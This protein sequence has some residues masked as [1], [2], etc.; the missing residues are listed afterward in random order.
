M[1]RVQEAYLS[2]FCIHKRPIL[3]RPAGNKVPATGLSMHPSK[4]TCGWSTPLMV[5]S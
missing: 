5:F 3:E 2:K 1:M 4:S